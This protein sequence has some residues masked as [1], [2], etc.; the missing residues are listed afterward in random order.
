MEKNQWLIEKHKERLER[1]A[2]GAWQLRKGY[3]ENRWQIKLGAA[4][5][6]GNHNA[7]C[8]RMH[9]NGMQLMPLGHEVRTTWETTEIIWLVLGMQEAKENQGGRKNLKTIKWQTNQFA[10]TADYVFM[11]RCLESP[12]RCITNPDYTVY[13]RPDTLGMWLMR[14]WKHHNVFHNPLGMRSIADP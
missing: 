7:Q 2:K 11:R 13:E 12:Q 4:G 6:R 14:N 8:T 3:S 1:H 10:V 5:R 9:V